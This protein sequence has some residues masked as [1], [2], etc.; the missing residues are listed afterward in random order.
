[1]ARKGT[2]VTEDTIRW[3]EIEAD[4]WTAARNAATARAANGNPMTEIEIETRA[5][6]AQDRED[7]RR[8]VKGGNL[9]ASCKNMS[10]A[11]LIEEIN[12]QLETGL[13]GNS[14]QAFK[15]VRQMRETS[16]NAPRRMAARYAGTCSR[17]S[18]TIAAGTEM[19]WD[20]QWHLAT[21]ASCH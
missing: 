20:P 9:S 13:Y 14:K 19:Y 11:E 2:T 7:I 18:T 5:R 4:A 17:C 6:N 15:A 16:A 12:R 1:M 3:S 8:T 21:C 10:R